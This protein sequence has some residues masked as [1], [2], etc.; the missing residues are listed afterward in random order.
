MTRDYFDIHGDSALPRF[1]KPCLMAPPGWLCTRD[2]GHKGPCAAVPRAERAYVEA[3]EAI[4]CPS[5]LHLLMNVST[6]FGN[7]TQQVTCCNPACPEVRI[8]KQYAR[9]YVELT[10]AHPPKE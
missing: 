2:A 7:P 1:K 4:G 10:R 6:P 9:R 3:H 5:C 8:V